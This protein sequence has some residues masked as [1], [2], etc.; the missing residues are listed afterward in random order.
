MELKELIN[1]MGNQTVILDKTEINISN[2]LKESKYKLLKEFLIDKNIKTTNDLKKM[3]QR[4]YNILKMNIPDLDGVGEERTSLFARKLDMIRN[5]NNSAEEIKK[6][7]KVTNHGRIKTSKN[8]FLEANYIDYGNNNE[9][10]D[11]RQIKNDNTRGKGISIKKEMIPEFKKMIENINLNNLD[12][13]NY[14]TNTIDNKSLKEKILDN[15][16]KL[17]SA[18]S[19]EYGQAINMFIKK[20]ESLS[21]DGDII[22]FLSNSSIEDIKKEQYDLYHRNGY[23][24]ALDIMNEYDKSDIKYTEISNLKPGDKINTM[25]LCALA[26]NFNLMLGMYYNEKEDYIILKSQTFGGDYNNKWIDENNMHYYLQNELENKYQTLEFSHKANQVCRDII[27]N[28]N[29]HTKVYLFDR[30][31]KNEDYNYCGE[32]NLIKFINDNKCIAIKK[33]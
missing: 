5:N 22:K 23:K 13:P 11:I 6:E 28:M 33:I 4:D 3:S 15:E 7:I 2:I 12:V 31:Y 17:L 21:K 26:N 10:L 20:I 24:T 8:W 19:N 32:V 18:F 30:H 27:L 9:F 29:S 1:Q 14:S 16:Y 25:T